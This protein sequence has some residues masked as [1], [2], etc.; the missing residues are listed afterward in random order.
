MDL[1]S[2]INQ[3]FEE[4]IQVKMDA[5]EVLAPALAQGVE[6]LVQGLMASG[7]ILV[8]GNGAS[9]LDAQR[10]A[11][12]LLD[13]FETERPSLAALALSCDVGMLST[14]AD[15]QRFDQVFAKQLQALGQPNDVLLVISP[16][17]N[18]VNVLEA[19]QVAHERE[20]H[21][22]AMT[23]SDGG[24]LV[25]YLAEGDVHLCAP[26]ARSARIQEIHLLALHC[27]CDGIDYS[28]LG[29]E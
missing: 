8:C 22:I 19:V 11:A 16:S 4:A 1:F 21:V 27:L 6:V 14:M 2:R 23:G 15:E 25:H 9:A 18:C 12:A 24:Q 10:F 7:K 5:L 20:M 13:R 26:S 3:Q 28:L 29:V 17:G